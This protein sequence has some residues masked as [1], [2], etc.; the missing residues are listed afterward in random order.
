MF[1]FIIKCDQ[2]QKL[3]IVENFNDNNKVMK[4]ICKFHQ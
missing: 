1:I 4:E 3:A 2:R